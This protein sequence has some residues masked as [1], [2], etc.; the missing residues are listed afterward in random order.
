MNTVWNSK[1]GPCKF[2][3]PL[4]ANFLI[5]SHPKTALANI[6]SRFV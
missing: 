3:T 2:L 5:E 4:K 1:G 6:Y